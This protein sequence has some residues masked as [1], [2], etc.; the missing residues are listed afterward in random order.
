MAATLAPTRPLISVQLCTYNRRALL[1]RVLDALFHQ[2][3]E[4]DDY[5][6]V[7]VD[8]G[9]NDGSYEQVLKN[10]K[11]TCALH[12]VRQRNAGLAAARNAGIERAR[13]SIILFMDD[14]VLATPGLLK[15]HLRFHATH[16][17]SICRGVAI[18]VESFD[19]LPP[20]VYSVRNYSGA[21]FW[22]TNVSVPLA[23]VIGAGRFDERFREYGWEDLELGFRLRRQGVPSVL[24]PDAV[25]YHHKPQRA[26][27]QFAGMAR[28]ARAQARTAMQFLDKHPHWRIALA[29]GQIAPM[30]WW[31]RLARRSGWPALLRRIAAPDAVR[32]AVPMGLRRWA[33]HRLAR[34]DYFDE[35]AN[36]RS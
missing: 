13:G 36:G 18:N 10:L 5:E 14:D 22:T 25:V 6:I 11:P 12:I 34:S 29:T 4:P 8:D 7:L 33:A 9:S 28:Q 3:L 30:L 17:N 32:S 16:A 20:P 35:L 19:A 1:G 15:A 27:E 31:S 23:L 24:A 2:E 26:P 21:Y